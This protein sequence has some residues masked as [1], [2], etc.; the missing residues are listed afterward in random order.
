MKTPIVI[1]H[2]G[3]TN[4][5]CVQ[6]ASWFQALFL[7]VSIASGLIGGSCHPE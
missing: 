1:S 3:T 6:P 4:A 2:P 5:G 7:M